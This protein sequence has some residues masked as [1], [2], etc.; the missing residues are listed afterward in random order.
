MII[1]IARDLALASMARD[2]L[3]ASST[4]AAGSSPAPYWTYLK[5][6][7][8]NFRRRLYNL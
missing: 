7:Q 2:D 6:P 3:P 8:K 1:I 4:V 5:S